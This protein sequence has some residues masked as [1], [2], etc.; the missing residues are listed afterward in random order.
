MKQYLFSYGTLLPDHAPDEIAATVRRLRP[1][2]R[3]FV[4][5]LVYNL[6]EY[7]GAVLSKKGPPIPGQVFELPDDPDILNRLDE[8]EEFDPAD[9]QASLFV[10]T[11]W[12]V[13]FQDGRKKVVCWVYAYNRQPG[14]APIVV[15]GDFAKPRN[16]RSR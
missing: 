12:P 14:A 13:T 6:G 9:P 11:K 5:G 8:Y 10:R 7:P 2:G 16:Q 3:G 4:R 15:G 1:V